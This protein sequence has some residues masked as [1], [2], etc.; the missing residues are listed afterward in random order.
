MKAILINTDSIQDLKLVAENEADTLYLKLLSEAGTLSAV[1]SSAGSSILFRPVSVV[2]ED[3]NGNTVNESNTISR[4]NFTLKQN[5]R[6]L[7]YMDFSSE[8]APMD[9]YAYSMIK[10]QVKPSRSSSP[11]ISLS[12]GD[13]LTIEGDDMNTLGILFTPYQTALLQLPVYYYD[14]LFSLPDNINTY[15]VEGE[16]NVIPSIT[17]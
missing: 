9:L 2:E 7:I 6:K 12:L 8:G 10:L 1:S 4:Y 17:R 16:I 14:L 3:F 11:V 15:T 5:E 13:G